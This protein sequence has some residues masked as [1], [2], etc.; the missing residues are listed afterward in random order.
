MSERVNDAGSG[1]SARLIETDTFP[2]DLLSL[3][4]ERE[5]WRKEI[6]RPLSHIHKWWAQRLGS[7]FRAILLACQLPDESDLLEEFYQK[8]DFPKTSVLDPF[9]GSG[10]TIAEAHKLGYTALGRD[11]NPVACESVRVALGAIDHDKLEAAFQNLSRTVGQQIRDIYQSADRNGQVC[12]VLYYFWVKT[13]ACPECETPV[14]L[15]STRVVARNACPERKP[16]IVVSCPSCGNLFRSENESSEAYCRICG[17][18]FA[19]LVGSTSG[20]DANCAG[21]GCKFS[22]VNALRTSKKPPHHRL[23]GKLLLTPNGNKVYLS[24]TAEDENRYKR[25]E[26]LLKTEL[27]RGTVHLP[28]S[29]LSEGFNTRQAMNYN[30]FAWRDFFNDRQLLALGWLHEAITQIRDISTRDAL[31]TLFSGL[32]EFN[33]MFASYKGEGTGAVRHMFSHHILK[34]ERMPIEA[35]VWGTTKSSGSF[36]NLFKTRLLRA[37][38]YRTRPFEPRIGDHKKSYNCNPPFSG[39]VDITWPTS[40]RFKQRGIYLSCGSSDQTGLP[41]E[42]IDLVITDPPFFDN[43]HYSEL[44]DFFYAWQALCPRGF[45]NGASTTRHPREVQD[46]LPERFATKLRDVFAECGRV[47]KANGMLVFTYHHSRP[48]GWT[49]L[50]SALFGAGFN[51]VNAHPVKSEMSVAA[52]KFQSK[53]PIQLDVILVCRKTP[54]VVIASIDFVAAIDRAAKRALEK[55]LRLYSAGI[56]LSRGDCRVTMISQFFA[57]TSPV[58]SGNILLKALEK[59]KDDLNLAADKIYETICSN[60]KTGSNLS[61]LVG[62]HQMDLPFI[63]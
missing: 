37:L 23:Y 51:V 20:P 19:P 2:I 4:A 24:T 1:Y 31:L 28:N 25:C 39:E 15:F 42:S 38:E 60:A 6:Y 18:S 33:N 41:E 44:A 30:Y 62:T 10:T 5:S 49:A 59:H 54:S 11:I 27:A 7:V 43:V 40:G 56:K 34:P 53:E 22:I 45:I 55:A 12:D 16:E 9:M 14:D 57:E 50:G 3:V 46:G 35:N 21:C 52:P 8:H 63:L 17:T 58:S 47:L 48:E 32:L 26:E 13:V 29:I 36:L 61:N